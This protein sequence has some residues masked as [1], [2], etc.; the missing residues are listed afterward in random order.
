MTIGCI[1]KK[2]AR[3]QAEETTRNEHDV[4]IDKGKN[5]RTL[6][7]CVTDAIRSSVKSLVIVTHLRIHNSGS[8]VLTH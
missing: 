8:V 1:L 6:R 3:C 4:E 7:Q 2:V 5:G